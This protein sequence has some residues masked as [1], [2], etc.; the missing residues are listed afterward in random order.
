MTH[1]IALTTLLAVIRAPVRGRY[2]AV[3]RPDAAVR[4]CSP[5]YGYRLASLARRTAFAR[6]LAGPEGHRG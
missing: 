6:Q 1:R 5:S 3:T 2:A 4:P